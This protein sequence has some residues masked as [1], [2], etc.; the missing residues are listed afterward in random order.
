MRYIEGMGIYVQTG[1]MDGGDDTLEE[2][3]RKKKRKITVMMMKTK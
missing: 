3:R 1:V 2:E